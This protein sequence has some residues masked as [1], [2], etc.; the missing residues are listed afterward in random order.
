MPTVWFMI[1]AVML[2]AYVVLD[3]F[4]LGAGIHLSLRGTNSR[5]T[6]H[7]APRDRP[8]VGRQ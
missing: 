8:G 5:R 3:G 1:V 4:D 6:P 2:A 7:G